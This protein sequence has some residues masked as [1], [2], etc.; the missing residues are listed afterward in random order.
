[1]IDT[2]ANSIDGVRAATIVAVLAVAVATDVVWRRIPNLLTGSAIAAGLLVNVLAG[3]MEGLVRSVAGFALGA[4]ILLGPVAVRWWG[5]GDLKLLAAL[6]AIGGPVFIGWAGLFALAAGGVIG[7][8]VLLA[9]RQAVPVLSGMAVDLYA[10]RAPRA[11]S[12]IHLPYA[13]PIAIGAVLALV[14][15]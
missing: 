6:G 8:A 4:V 13:V 15:R 1:M 7:V 9:R 14:V 11:A 3:G 2:L 10:A 5:A 12:G